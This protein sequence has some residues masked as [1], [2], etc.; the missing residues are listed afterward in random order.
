MTTSH[1][2]ADGPSGLPAPVTCGWPAAIPA[3]PVAV[4]VCRYSPP[5]DP[6][7]PESRDAHTPLPVPARDHRPVAG[8]K[9]RIRH[10]PAAPYR[11]DA[12]PGHPDAAAAPAIQPY[13]L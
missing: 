12:R 8:G 6:A 10:H 3:P 9:N 11:P 5:D 13:A 2:P 4:H 7:P 1:A